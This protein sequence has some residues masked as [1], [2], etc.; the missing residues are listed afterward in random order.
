MQRGLP[1]EDDNVSIDEV[2]LNLVARLQ[3]PILQGQGTYD[4]FIESKFHKNEVMPSTLTTNL[5]C[6]S[7]LGIPQLKYIKASLFI[8]TR[9]VLRYRKSS[10]VPSSRMIKRAPVCPGGGCGP[11]STNWRI[12]QIGSSTICPSKT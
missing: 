6:H 2:T 9:S 8:L 11:F 12:L 7:I 10:L 4:T 1:V 3:M 5:K